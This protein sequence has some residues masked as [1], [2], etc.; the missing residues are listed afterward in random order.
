[1]VSNNENSDN[2]STN[3][4]TCSICLLEL[5]KHEKTLDCQHIFHKKCID[6]WISNNNTCPLCRKI[7]PIL[8]PIPTITKLPETVVINIY[9][10]TTTR[11]RKIKPIL[12]I[13]LYILV[14]L[15][16]I[17]SSLYNDITIFKSNKYINN[18]I[19][20]MNSTEFNSTE[21][22]STEFNSTEFNSTKLNNHS[23][24]TYSG[25]VLIVCDIVFLI[26]YNILNNVI[27][28]VKASSHLGKYVCI[29]ASLLTIGIIRA[30]FYK[31]TNGYLNDD[32]L[33][34]YNEE[35]NN[36]MQLSIML[37]GISTAVQ[38]FLSFPLYMNS[39][40]R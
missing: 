31:N 37:F 23:S 9:Q 22:N 19:S 8:I 3:L 17:S 18:M 26:I 36:Q 21:F 24:T 34:I 29:G 27:I 38:I 13:I 25:E 32:A 6:E 35:Y 15:F 12:Y 2:I 20:N 10:P 28:F 33:D 4:I 14:L 7:I 40:Q 1:M 39:Y 5:K 16:F 11:I 30:E